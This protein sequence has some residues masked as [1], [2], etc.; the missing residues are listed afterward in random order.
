MSWTSAKLRSRADLV[1]KHQA[2]WAVERGLAWLSAQLG[3]A[4]I[5][6]FIW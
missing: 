5:T 1:C 4:I 3:Q 6:L 2:T